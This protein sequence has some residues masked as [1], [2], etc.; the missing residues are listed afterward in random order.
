VTSD[1]ATREPYRGSAVSWLVWIMRLNAVL[2]L[3]FFTFALVGTLGEVLGLLSPG[4]V[5]SGI[6]CRVRWGQGGQA[7]EMMI[8]ALYLVWGIFL[9]TAARAPLRNRTFL[10]FT[11]A[12]NIAH[13]GAMFLEAVLMPNETSHLTGDVLIFP[14]LLVLLIAAWAPLRRYAV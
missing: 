3:T 1:S 11:I 9:L 2:Y 13:F 10:D 5:G 14:A 7:Y 4:A 12:G 6:I 8:S